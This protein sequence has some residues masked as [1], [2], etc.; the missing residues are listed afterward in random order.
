MTARTKGIISNGG[1]L[2]FYKH[3]PNWFTIMRS[4][5]TCFASCPRLSELGAKAPC[6]SV[7]CKQN[8]EHR[9]ANA[10][11]CY[12]FLLP[13]GLG[14]EKFSQIP[15]ESLLCAQIRL[16]CA[17][18]L[19]NFLVGGLFIWAWA[20]IFVGFGLMNGQIY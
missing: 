6:S 8:P 18:W 13:S 17:S 19:L 9:C 12:K 2:I 15:A 10:M 5:P 20:L 16:I 7:F 1:G 4:K 14:L 3:R 11:F